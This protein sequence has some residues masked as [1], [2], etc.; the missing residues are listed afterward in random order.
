MKY[1]L[2]ILFFIASFVFS[3]CEKKYKDVADITYF[4]EIQIEGEA[5]VFTPSGIEYKDLGAIAVENGDTVNI[6]TY[7]N[8][9]VNN[10]GTYTVSYS[11]VNSDGFK[12]TENRKVVV[13]D[14]NQNSLD[15]SGTYNVDVKRDNEHY[16]NDKV[17]LTPTGYNGVY[18]ISDWVGGFYSTGRGYGDAYKFQG[19]IQINGNNEVLEL[20]MTNVW[21]E[22]FEQLTG[23]YNTQT[24]VIKYNAT[25]AGKSP[26]I[27]EL[28]K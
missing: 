5:T 12:K 26:F 21:N 24:G 25:I 17:E 18:Y 1:N 27:V 11:A 6:E 2:Y 22:P 16:T 7:S 28:S 14:S 4:V 20:E 15:L 9:D 13:Y 19:I 8:V 3:S 10:I 23:S